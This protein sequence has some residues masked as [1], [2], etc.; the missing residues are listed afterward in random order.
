MR[1]VYSMLR[2]DEY[3]SASRYAALINTPFQRGGTRWSEAGNRFNG[4]PQAGQT[5]E[6]VRRPFAAVCTPLK[7]GVDE[8]GLLSVSEFR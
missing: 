1:Q 7:R 5:V 8:T 6:S 2:T 4:F 3:M